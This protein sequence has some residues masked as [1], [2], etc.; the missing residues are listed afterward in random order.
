M[1]IDLMKKI[2]KLTSPGVKFLY[3]NNYIITRFIFLLMENGIH[4]T[5]QGWTFSVTREVELEKKMRI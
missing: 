1:S 3:T 5:V 4:E 2:K